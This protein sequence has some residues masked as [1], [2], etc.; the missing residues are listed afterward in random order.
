MESATEQGLRTQQLVTLP[1]SLLRGFSLQN[2][3]LTHSKSFAPSADTR[4][5]CR[6]RNIQSK[7]EEQ[8]SGH[9]IYD[10][11]TPAVQWDRSCWGSGL[12]Q[13]CQR[14][15]VDELCAECTG[16]KTV[17]RC[18]P[19]GGAGAPSVLAFWV[20]VGGMYVT[21]LGVVSGVATLHSSVRMPCGPDVVP[22]EDGAE[23]CRQLT[24]SSLGLLEPA[25]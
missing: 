13:W 7:L 19:F 4:D 9:L 11:I 2:G 12:P 22:V 17:P 6:I 14:C 16:F 3:E 18:A 25:V 8:A 24:C 23:L 10:K 15:G 20:I 5:F 1:D 21:R